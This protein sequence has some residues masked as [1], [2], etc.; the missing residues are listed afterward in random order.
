M[1]NEVNFL[2]VFAKYSE[3]Y[4]LRIRR[5]SLFG[6]WECIGPR[7]ECKRVPKCASSS[8]TPPPHLLRP[9]PSIRRL[10]C[11]K[12]SQLAALQGDGPEWSTPISLYSSHSF[13]QLLDHVSLVFVICLHT[14]FLILVEHPSNILLPIADV[15]I[16]LGWLITRQGQ[17]FFCVHSSHF[18]GYISE[19]HK[20]W[21]WETNLYV[22]WE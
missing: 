1:W 18:L 6:Y 14:V 3:I 12:P 4:I 9:L 7:T 11:F 10:H 16:F 17:R 21:T 22:Y 19:R 5:M 13:V 2:C 8:P 15:V 20:P